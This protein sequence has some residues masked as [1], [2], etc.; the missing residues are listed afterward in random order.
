MKAPLVRKADIQPSANRISGPLSYNQRGFWFAHQWDPQSPDYNRPA[1]FRLSGSLD[2]ESLEK[3]LNALVKRHPI[4]RTVYPVV[5]G[6]PSQRVLPPGD[7]PIPL[8]DLTHIPPEDRMG[9]VLERMKQVFQQPFDLEAGPVLRLRLYRLATREYVLLFIVHIIAI[10]GWSE[11]LFLHDLGAL[12]DN[13][14]NGSSHTLPEV[15]IQY[16]DFSYWQ[17]DHA[18]DDVFT[19]H[20]TYWKGKLGDTLQPLDIPTDRPLPA[21]QTY[22]G[23]TVFFTISKDRVEELVAFSRRQGVTLFMVLLAAFKTLAFRYT[24]QIDIIV[25][26]PIAGRTSAVLDKIIGN[27]TNDLILRTDFSG[28]PTFA[29]LLQRLRQ[30]CLEAYEHQDLP[31]ERVVEELQPGRDLSRP[32]FFQVMFNFEN[33][34]EN[35]IDMGEVVV[36]RVPSDWG[37]ALLDMLVELAWQDEALSGT[38]LYN[39]DLF[40]RGRIDRMI[41]HYQILLEKIVLNPNQRISTLP[42][43]TGAEQQTIIVDWNDTRRDIAYEFV[44][45]RFEKQV[46]RDPQAIAFE[47][48]SQRLTYGELNARV[49]QLARY[50]CSLGVGPDVLVVI[51]LERSVEMVLSV[52]AV[53]KAGGAYVPLDFS[54][55]NRRLANF[56]E[57]TQPLVII[58]QSYFSPQLPEHSAKAVYLDREEQVV[59]QYSSANLEVSLD[60]QNLAYLIFTSG[61]TG[62]PKGVMIDHRGFSNFMHW[63]QATL[64][65]T[66][67]DR[68]LHRT[69]FGF[70]ASVREFFWPL[71]AGARLVMVS[72]QDAKDPV[73]NVRYMAEKHIT[74][75]SFGSTQLQFI[76]DSPGIDDCK[77]LRMVITGNEALLYDVMENYYQRLDVPLYNAYGPTE[78]TMYATR[79][80]C[81]LGKYDHKV[82]IGRPNPNYRVYILDSNMQP[83]PIGV[84]GELYIGGIC[85]A[86]GYI[87]RPGLTADRF[88]PDPFTKEPGER[89]YRTGDHVRYLPDGNIEFLGRIDFQVKIRG[90]RIELGEIEAVLS[91]HPAVKQAAVSVWENDD[92]GKYLAAYLVYSHRSSPSVAEIR[93]Y[94]HQCLPDY[95]L[96]VT[97]LSMESLPRTS[98][99]KINRAG[100]PKPEL[101]RKQLETS[102]VA[103]RTPVEKK[104]AEIWSKLVGLEEIGVHDDFFEIGGHSLLAARLIFNLRQEFQ[105]D[106]PIASLFQYPTIASFAAQLESPSPKGDELSGRNLSLIPIQPDGL[107]TPL[108]LVP[109]GGGGEDE[110]LIYAPLIHHFGSE[111]PVYGLL[112]RGFSSSEPPHKDID[113]MVTDYLSEIRSVQTVGPYLLAGECIGGKVAY[114]MAR[115]LEQNGQQVGLLILMN[116]I[117]PPE[118]PSLLWRIRNRILVQ[119]QFRKFGSKDIFGKVNYLLHGIGKVIWRLISINGQDEVKKRH[120]FVRQQYRKIVRGYRPTESYAGEISLL[121]SADH[122]RRDPSLGWDSLPIGNLLIHKLDGDHDSYIGEHVQKTANK[123][124][125]CLLAAHQEMDQGL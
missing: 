45:H 72:E 79:W 116:T 11:S 29:Q 6:E 15:P 84:P 30:T 19:S 122:H 16:I 117:L 63:L 115:R 28:D 113:T 75:A 25:G 125:E 22:N 21:E 41:D 69:T 54:E 4:L 18:R 46:E 65:L 102:Y 58:T 83:V 14:A 89:L 56:I 1:A 111:Q 2:I 80:R 52:L 73:Y 121:V 90:Y 38:L 35:D 109:G 70:D 62:R 85:L 59:S 49:N 37:V 103:P 8:E 20:S 112:A 34:P 3:A 108:F 66:P 94:L 17:R 81:E 82:S 93:Q 43:L 95:M 64:T 24:G 31:F 118:S 7:F 9:K 91:A 98:N 55:P 107:R 23:Q 33:L 87:N 97:Y 76:L 48:H 123:L 36:E 110:F 53:L 86:R 119:R 60:S 44:H 120:Q 92:M 88:V 78:T 68:V 5:D 74:C 39:S 47:L 99:G 42:I 61:S 96:P 67:E 13:F 124:S 71:I 40:D 10:D 12:Y 104:L 32:P 101:D 57:D 105:V 100:L 27:F 106:F 77:T 51:Y 114:E 26:S 50:L